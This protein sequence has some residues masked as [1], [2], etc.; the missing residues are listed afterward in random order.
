[1]RLAQVWLKDFL[2]ISCFDGTPLCSSDW[3]LYVSVCNILIYFALT[4]VEDIFLLT[5]PR[6][7]AQCFPFET[8]MDL[9]R[10]TE[11]SF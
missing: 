5:H 7:L 1:M 2:L 10:N 4:N 11:K 9:Q 3:D 6:R 8:I